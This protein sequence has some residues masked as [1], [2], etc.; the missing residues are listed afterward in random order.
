MKEMKTVKILFSAVCILFLLSISVELSAQ[1]SLDSIVKGFSVSDNVWKSHEILSNS[2]HYINI[3]I[4]DDE[5]L[6]NEFVKVFNSERGKASHFCKKQTEGKTCSESCGF[7]DREN[8]VIYVY[9][10]DRKDCSNM[11]IVYVKSN[12]FPQKRIAEQGSS[13]LKDS[14]NQENDEQ[15]FEDF[16]EKLKADAVS[17]T[18]GAGTSTAIAT[19][20]HAGAV[21]AEHAG[22]AARAEAA[23]KREEA[24]AKRKEAERIREEVEYAR[25]KA[26]AERAKATAA[27]AKDA[28]KLSEANSYDLKDSADVKP[29]KPKY[30][31]S[32]GANFYYGG[33]KITV[34]EAKEMGLD[35]E[36]ID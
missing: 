2:Y 7:E 28:G 34:K 9:S 18:G 5:Q 24:A 32:K 20:E 23:A 22:V 29:V 11:K 1:H 8:N 33:K 35:V 21:A 30:Y 14:K 13:D 3:V 26:T 27:R 31:V 25:D 6:S 4:E 10:Y 15:M 19:A 36:E 16:V 12:I 17:H